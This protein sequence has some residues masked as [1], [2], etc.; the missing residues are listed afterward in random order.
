MPGYSDHEGRKIAGD[1]VTFDDVLLVPARSDVVPRE[2]DLKTK[3]TRNVTINT[4]IV[5]A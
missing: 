3:L 5:S 1:G 4:P 2:V